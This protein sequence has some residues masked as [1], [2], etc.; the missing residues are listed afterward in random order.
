MSIQ[1][2][3]APSREVIS[4]S[5]LQEVMD[6]MAVT[7]ITQWMN[8]GEES[9]CTEEDEDEY[10]QRLNNNAAHLF[11]LSDSALRWD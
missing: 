5:D 8:R 9:A 4:E 7:G 2:M 1:D 11:T 10:R 6:D 3:D